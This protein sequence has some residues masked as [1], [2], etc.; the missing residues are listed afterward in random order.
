VV[1]SSGT[2][3]SADVTRGSRLT[4]R[5]VTRDGWVIGLG[6]LRPDGAADRTAMVQDTV[7]GLVWD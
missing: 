4:D 3:T 5:Y 7:A 6:Y 2:L 1:R